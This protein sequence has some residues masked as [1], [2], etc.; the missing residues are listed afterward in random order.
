[1]SSF[2]G[3]SN[4][5]RPICARFEETKY[6]GILGGFRRPV[7]EEVLK[8]CKASPRHRVIRE[9]TAVAIENLLSRPSDGDLSAPTL[10]SGQPQV[11]R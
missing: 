11:S 3:D 7:N 4:K 9:G 6:L 2:H 8:I 1:M 5:Y 10:N